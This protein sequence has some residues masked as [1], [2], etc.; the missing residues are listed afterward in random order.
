MALQRFGPRRANRNVTDDLNTTSA[1][2]GNYT[3][4]VSNVAE[5]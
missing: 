4:V 5:W 3:V 2:E 1:N